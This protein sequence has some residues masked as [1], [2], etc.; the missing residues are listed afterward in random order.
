MREKLRYLA[1]CVSGC[2]AST[3]PKSLSEALSWRDEHRDL[4]H[5]VAVLREG[6][7][8]PGRGWGKP[9]RGAARSG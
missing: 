7:S 8:R 4:G 6:E 1:T 5:V 9:R 2:G 3:E